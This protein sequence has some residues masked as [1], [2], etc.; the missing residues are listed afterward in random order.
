MSDD[1]FQT[2]NNNTMTPGQ[3]LSDPREVILLPDG[4]IRKIGIVVQ[5]NEIVAEPTSQ[6]PDGVSCGSLLIGEQPITPEPGLAA[7][8]AI[9]CPECSFRLSEKMGRPVRAMLPIAA[10]IGQQVGDTLAAADI[11]EEEASDVEEESEEEK[12][13]R[14]IDE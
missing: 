14:A 5:C 9:E 3:A 6:N 8:L 1:I 7:E 2:P 11:E 10:L 13:I 12:P 4:V